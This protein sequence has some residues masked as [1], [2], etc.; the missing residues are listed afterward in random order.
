M[1]SLQIIPQY[2]I[3]KLSYNSTY[4]LR[5][6]LRKMDLQVGTTFNNITVGISS[7]GYLARDIKQG[8]LN[9][10]YA[11]TALRQHYDNPKETDTYTYIDLSLNSIRRSI[12]LIRT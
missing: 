9:K 12:Q 2:Y 6:F 3:S 7:K 1:Q 4:Y 11:V 8:I 5:F 10:G